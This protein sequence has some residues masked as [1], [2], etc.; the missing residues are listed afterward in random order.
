MDITKQFNP[1]GAD[2]A[3]APEQLN[4]ETAVQVMGIK[5]VGEQQI[6]ELMQIL[7]KYRAGKNSIDTR[8]IAAENWWKL[9]NDVEEDKA[10]HLKPGFRS[11]SGWLHN[12]I[13]NKHADA[14]D[15]YPEPNI[16]PREQGD[17]L[18][19]A[20]LSKIIP[21]VL[22]K[23]QFE[24]TYSRVM[25]S[26]L[27]TG[28]GAYKVIWDKNKLNGLGD[29]NVQKCN[30]L[31]LFWEPGVEDIQQSKY[32]FEV[33]FQDEDDVRE[34]FPEEL[35][36]GKNIPHDFITSKFRYD[37]HVDTTNKVPVISAYYHKGG[38][39]H[40]VL[41]VPGTVLYA[42][43]ND[44]ERAVMGWYDHGKYPYVF[45]ALFPVEGSP[46]GY[47]YVDL[48][49][50][51]QTEIDLLKTAYVEN[52]MVGAK[53]RYFK[54]ANC[55]VNVEQFTDLNET[56][57]NV[58]GSLSD[59][60]LLPV[61]HDNLDGNYISMLELSINELRETSGNTETATGTTSSGVTAASA[62]AALQEASG[63][64][65]RDS[66]KGSYRAYS[67]VDF[68]VI[69]LIRQFYD[70]P[71]QFRILG[72]SGEEM[73]YSYSNARLQP[74]Q[75][76]LGSELTGYRVPEF[77]IRVV[78]QK[79][80]AYTKMSNNEL[81]LQFY[82]LGFFNPQQTDQALACLS[83]MDFDSIDDVRKTI[84][85]NGTMYE[86]YTMM[87][88]IAA[89]LAAKC[90]DAQAMAQIQA[91]A[92]QGGAQLPNMPTGDISMPAEDPLKGEHT[93]VTN[94]RAQSRQAAMPDGGNAT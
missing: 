47:G 65:S 78:P 25:W 52:A 62:I 91:L 48:C 22:E 37:D 11:K 82:G 10:G 14:M 45:D 46:C 24:S 30:I 3:D 70:A 67:E 34:M 53:P 55:G 69:E 35:P 73:F 51:P 71:R 43:E 83:M 66:T 38:V 6:N 39:L 50:A 42:T 75:Q 72:D 2:G 28:T 23:N 93:G 80:S 40:Y 68:L 20:M 81:A 79:R 86:R 44:P 33:D 15:A 29:I 41:F 77:D 89:L 16:L 87:M 76:M 5:P 57:I 94:A 58:E 12:V 88:Q 54:K 56:L 63:K 31:N 21:V 85:Q 49:K 8:I 17:K 7:T 27:K 26:K 74:Q 64:G 61:T 84:K 32:F 92:Q 36:E 19:A 1:L 4:A 18:E 59:E 9:R 13:T 60:H 90:G